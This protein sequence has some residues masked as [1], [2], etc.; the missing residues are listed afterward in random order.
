R[1]LLGSDL[2]PPDR[3]SGMSL[4][5]D[6][7]HG[8]RVAKEHLRV[9]GSQSKIIS[10]IWKRKISPIELFALDVSKFV[11][12]NVKIF[13][14]YVSFEQRRKFVNLETRFSCI[15]YPKRIRFGLI[16][17]DQSLSIPR[18]FKPSQDRERLVNQKVRRLRNKAIC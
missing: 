6:A 2:L 8:D 11:D 5:R 18:D 17:H 14:E 1:N 4:G 10:Q 3:G 16:S 13:H 15:K 9:L 7:P 12:E